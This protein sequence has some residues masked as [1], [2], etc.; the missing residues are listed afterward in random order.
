MFNGQF[1]T[2]PLIVTGG[3]VAF[4]VAIALWALRMTAAVRSLMAK[5]RTR[6]EELEW[7]VDRS[8][9]IFSAHPGVIMVW[10]DEGAADETKDPFQDFPDFSSDFEFDEEHEPAAKPART[11]T[12]WGRPRLFGSPPALLAML[13][14][15]D[16][17][18]GP[19]AGSHILDGL[20]DYDAFSITPEA[21]GGT[22]GEATTLRRSLQALRNTGAPFTLAIQGPQGRRIEAEGRPAGRRAVL[23]LS[24]ATV[25]SAEISSSRLLLAA[26]RDLEPA[27]DPIAFVDLLA[28]APFPMFRLSSG[29][30]LLYANPAYLAAVE[31]R[32]YNDAIQRDL[33]LDDKVKDQ[34]RRALDESARTDDIRAINVAG[35]RR[36]FAISIFPISGGVAG[37]AIDVTREQEAR[38][39]LERHARAQDDALNHLRD[40]VAIFGPDQKLVFHNR[41]FRALF[42]L[43]ESWL[44]QRPSHGELLDRL[45]E[46]RLIPE[47]SNYQAWRQRELGRYASAAEEAPEEVWTLPDE[48]ML[49]VARLRHPLG[50]V[51]LI[52]DDMT[53]EVALETEFNTL[54]KVQRATL[55]R[56]N[57]GVAVFGPDG[58]LRLHNAAFETM[59]DIP[60]GEL[61]VNESF[62]DVVKRCLK[63]FADR[64]E[65]AEIKAR[66]TDV[67]P[68]ARR[69]VSREIRRSDDTVLTYL[70]RPLPDGSTVIAFHDVTAARRLETAL[71]DRTDALEAADRVKSRFVENVSYHLRAPLTTVMGFA[72]LLTVTGAGKLSESEA[73]QLSAIVQASSDLNKLVEDIID[74]A[75]IDAQTMSL[76]MA[77]ME[78]RSTL[79]SA[80]ALV[81]TRAAETQIHLSIACASDTGSIRADRRRVRQAVYYLVLNA[82][83]HTTAGG[84][85]EVGAQRVGSSVSIW[86]EDDGAGIPPDK[87]GKVFDPFEPSDR[88]GAGLGL[89]L[90]RAFV[91]LHNGWVDIES[92]VGVGTRVTM[93]LPAKPT[94]AAGAKALAGAAAG[95]G[96]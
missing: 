22:R 12:D 88:R 48:R 62:D 83:E 33:Q 93:H 64:N 24:D 51:L 71:K 85:I 63:L 89:T 20:A 32:T 47:Q 14:L 90:V 49:R 96:D 36:W 4:G 95:R 73:S 6:V 74:I 53:R 65:W 87:Q 54:I 78:V 15:A 67:S 55:D 21:P 45:R 66:V 42:A 16:A 75:A 57:E 58:R 2:A 92:D 18:D 81:T 44:N 28:K 84:S 34:A 37:A 19:D 9:G 13:R 50:G 52:F 17:S 38:T 27:A 86:V 26:P 30:K 41:A 56:L 60:A 7:K 46:R 35:Q 94:R 3:A 8:D 80:L 10:E 11:S 61:A 1:E 91:E 25:K 72:E 70:Q 79:E 77:D 39:A 40:A 76:D 5:W 82:I 68:E 59:W 31:A 29:L 23:W 69:A 43:D